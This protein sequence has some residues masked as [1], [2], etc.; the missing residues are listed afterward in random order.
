V[1]VVE[2]LPGPGGVRDQVVVLALEVVLGH[3]VVV[4][5]GE[6]LLPLFEEGVVLCA[7]RRQRAL[8]AVGIV[9]FAARAELGELL[10]RVLQ[11]DAVVGVETLDRR[12]QQDLDAGAVALLADIAAGPVEHAAHAGVGAVA[13]PEAVAVRLAAREV[14]VHGD[15]L[16]DGVGETGVHL[17]VA[18]IVG[19]EQRALQAEQGGVAERLAGRHVDELLQE[20]RIETL[21]FEADVAEVEART[22]LELQRDVGAV[23]VEVDLDAALHEPG[24]QIAA[25]A[26]EAP[27][28]RLGALVGGV[29]ER[30][31]GV[32]AEVGAIRLAGALARDADVDLAEGDRLPSGDPVGRDPVAFGCLRQ[33]VL[34]GDPVETERRERLLDL[35]GRALVQALDPALGQ[36]VGLTLAIDREEGLDVPRLIPVQTL[37]LHL[38]RALDGRGRQ[39]QRRRQTGGEAM[40][41]ARGC[42]LR[43]VGQGHRV[44]DGVWRTARAL[45]RP[46]P[47]PGT[48]G[49]ERARFRI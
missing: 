34:H 41:R 43:G 31:A 18:E 29:I 16:V 27:E 4:V 12:R 30:R 48:R 40:A 42:S 14:D 5:D 37:Q 7:Q 26:R 21:L 38:D 11:R 8:A 28:R 2:H 22:G 20:R 25:L 32:E 19:I 45:C 24:V 46:R 6:D 33:R 17:D 13:K 35:L 10:A 9:P 36:L 44:G 39:Q 49:V 3:L 47:A 23:G 15:P 1:K